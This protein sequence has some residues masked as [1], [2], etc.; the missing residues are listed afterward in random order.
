MNRRTFLGTIPFA[1]SVPLLPGRSHFNALFLVDDED[2]LIC[3]K[4]F[5]LAVSLNLHKRLMNEVIVE[6]GKSFLGADYVA[7]SLEA[8][9]EERL[10]VNLRGLDCV[11]LCENSLSL[12]RCVKKNTMTFEAYKA[13]LQFIRYRGGVINRYPSRLH[14]FSD[15]IY[16]NE[17][18][19]V[20]KDITKSIGGVPYKKTIDFMSTHVD[21]Y[22]QLKEHPE[23]V[24]MIARQEA[25]INKREM[26]HI[27]KADIE[28]FAS[29]I[30]SGDIL[31]ITCTIPGLDIAHTGIA[32]WQNNKLHFMHAPNVGQKVVITEKTLAEYLADNKKQSGIMVARALEPI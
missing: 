9:G 4:K 27:P 19:G 32:I 12:A 22:P 6:I 7:H 10:V 8:P 2:A 14:Y 26:Y 23:F 11:L 16:D 28:K 13:E 5:D 15:Y 31:A 20:L 3:A 17:K 18:K 25:E 21:S 24:K 29:K 1:A 30:K